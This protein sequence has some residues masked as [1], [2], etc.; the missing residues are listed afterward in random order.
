MREKPAVPFDVIVSNP[1]YI[2]A[3]DPHLTQ[4]DLR[5]EPAQ[6]LI[7]GAGG[8]DALRQIIAHAPAWLKPDGQI[9][10]EHGYNQ[11]QAVQALLQQAGFQQIRSLPDLAGI[12]RVTGGEWAKN[13]RK[14]N[15][16]NG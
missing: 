9:W 4:G 14:N 11:A 8:L 15:R 10:L 1:P 6:A 2:A 12:L 5:F 7:G 16:K 3:D 13:G